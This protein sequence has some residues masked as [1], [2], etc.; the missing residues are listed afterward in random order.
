MK[1]NKWIFCIFVCILACIIFAGC[2]GN[3]NVSGDGAPTATPTDEIRSPLSAPVQPITFTDIDGAVAFLKNNNL[4]EYRE[5]ERIKYAEMIAKIN[6]KGKVPYFYCNNGNTLAVRD[7]HLMP[8]AT[9]EDIGVTFRTDYNGVFYYIA[10]YYLDKDCIDMTDNSPSAY[11]KKRFPTTGDNH[12]T[13]TTV[14]FNGKDYAAETVT[15]EQNNVV[16]FIVDGEYM[17]SVRS[18][19]NVESIRNMIGNIVLDYKNID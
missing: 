13:A 12:V 2:S 14:N 9:Y 6:G 5:E 4:Q 8:E 17:I 7:A 18:G 10:Y 1:S 15:F 19:D 3:E 11:N 16:R